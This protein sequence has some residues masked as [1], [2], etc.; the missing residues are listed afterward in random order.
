[1]QDCTCH[2]IITESEEESESTVSTTKQDISERSTPSSLPDIPAPEDCTEDTI[3]ANKNFY[4]GL[5]DLVPWSSLPEILKKDKK[6]IL[7]ID[8]PGYCLIESIIA[9]L[10]EGY[11]ICYTK[12]EIIE[13]MSKELVQNPDYT[14]YMRIPITQEEVNFNLLSM[15]TSKK[16][17]SG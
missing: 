10:S 8:G 11:N 2:S 9:A 6:M 7:Q 17:F 5:R 14:R 12:D 4:E 1:M 3:A 15:T 16:L 13:F